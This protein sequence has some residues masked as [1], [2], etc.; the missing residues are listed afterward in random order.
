MVDRLAQRCGHAGNGRGVLRA[1]ALAALLRAALDDVRERDAAPGVQKADAARAVEL[2]RRAREQV[3]VHRLHVHGNV[4]DGLHRVRVERDAPLAAERADGLNGLDG[5]DLVV[6]EH[7]GHE[8]RVVPDG[9][10]HVLDADD[11]VFVHIQQR[12]VKALL[13][14]L[15]ERVQHRMVLEFRGYQMLFPFASAVSGGGNDGLIVSLAAAGGEHDL[16]RVGSADQL[17]DLGAAGEQ[18]LGRLLPEG[19]ERAGIAVDLVKIRKH[20]FLCG[21]G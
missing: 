6:G 19:V 8:R 20:G 5:A 9:R 3:D 12:H 11:A 4:A 14:E 21:G 2:V 17:R 1:A 7:D 16:A 18:M 15:V 10:G 13:T